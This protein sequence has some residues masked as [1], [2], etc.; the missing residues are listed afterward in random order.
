MNSH[1]ACF[2]LSMLCSVFLFAGEVSGKSYETTIYRDGFG[3]PH[4][5]ADSLPDAAFGDGYAQAQDRMKL[6]MD[7]ILQATGTRAAVLGKRFVRQDYGARLT[8]AR[9]LAYEAWD[10]INP[11]VKAVLEGFAAGVNQFMVDHPEGLPPNARQIDA[12]EI[13]AL[14][15]FMLL[16]RQF[17]QA[18]QDRRRQGAVPISGEGGVENTDGGSNGWVLAPSRTVSGNPIVLC[19]PHTPWSSYNR[20]YEKHYI[21]PEVN[22][23]GS[24]TTG[25]PLFLYG[26][27]DHV[28][29]T[30]TRN[31]GDR[32][33]CFA[34]EVVNKRKYKFDGKPM[35]F[36]MHEEVIEVKG[37]DPVRRQVLHTIHGPVF[38]REGMTA[39]VAGMSMYKSD[40]Q[41][42]ELL[43]WMLAKDVY[44]FKDA[45]MKLEADG[46]NVFVADAK[47]NYGYFWI[48][49]MMVRNDAFHWLEP[50]DGSNAESRYKGVLPFERLPQSINDKGGYY[51]ASNAA[52]WMMP[53]GAWGMKSGDF[54]R[55]LHSYNNRQYFSAR[56]Q[57]VVDLIESCPKHSLQQAMV[58]AL[59]SRVVAAEW[60]M[61]ALE[62]GFKTYGEGSKPE[63][64]EATEIL[65]SWVAEGAETN[66]ESR[67]YTIFRELAAQ[68]G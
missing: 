22:I 8:G 55:W 48:N 12:Q 18:R 30:L 67:G 61:P 60:A 52:N 50:V 46:V 36:V 17:N 38:E 5:V 33:D 49:R 20:W 34:V 58:M 32:G 41:G 27:S 51:Q 54:P 29:W 21:T 66:G 42:D 63:V 37:A 68:V 9:R 57:R 3:V 53:E 56:P 13:L 2:C 19:D 44:D 14:N 35:N 4:I 43:G 25:V 16:A 11:E 31:P 40:F 47:G 65:R 39:F 10:G 45:L 1:N 7:N 62:L 24:M 6:V 28:S 23:Y 15:Q 64:G 59:D 26:T